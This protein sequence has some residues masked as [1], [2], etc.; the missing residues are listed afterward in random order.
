[1][2][3]LTTNLPE[4]LYPLIWV[5]EHFTIDKP[6]ADK[7]YNQVKLPLMI[8]DYGKWAILGVG[9]VFSILSLTYASIFII[10]RRKIIPVDLKSLIV[11]DGNS[12]ENME[13]ESKLPFDATAHEDQS[14]EDTNK[15]KLSDNPTVILIE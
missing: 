15:E 14:H 6:N 1:M 11:N 5:D 2:I 4:I 7:F 8:V 10:N 3:R 9:I 12:Y 13:S